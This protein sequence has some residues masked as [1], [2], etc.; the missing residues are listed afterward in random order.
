MLTIRYLSCT[1]ASEILA[2]VSFRAVLNRPLSQA[3]LQ[4]I[5]EAVLE[6]VA[7]VL[8]DSYT[9]ISYNITPPSSA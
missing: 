7:G 9:G 1:R 6:A 5:L 3:D 4:A 8:L 2:S